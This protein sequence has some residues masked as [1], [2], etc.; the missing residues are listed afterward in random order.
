MEKIKVLLEKYIN[1]VKEMDETINSVGKK[2]ILLDLVMDASKNQLWD[3]WYQF[4]QIGYYT[5]DKRKIR[6]FVMDV[7][8]N[9]YKEDSDKAFDITNNHEIE[10]AVFNALHKDKEEYLNENDRIISKDEIIESIYPCLPD[11]VAF[12]SN[13]Y[14]N[15]WH[16]TFTYLSEFLCKGTI[17]SRSLKIGSKSFRMSGAYDLDLTG[18]EIELDQNS[19]RDYLTNILPSTT[20]N[21]DDYFKTDQYK[22]DVKDYETSRPHVFYDTSYDYDESNEA[23]DEIRKMYNES[24]DILEVSQSEIDILN[25][26]YKD[27]LVYPI[28]S[29][30]NRQYADDKK[31]KYIYTYV[32]TLKNKNPNSSLNVKINSSNLDKLDQRIENYLTT[33][34]DENVSI[35][36]KYTDR[37]K[38]D[39]YKSADGQWVIE[40]K[41]GWIT[42]YG[43]NYIISKSKVNAIYEL[44]LVS[45]VSD[46]D[47][48]EAWEDYD[49]HAFANDVTVE[50]LNNNPCSF[51]TYGSAGRVENKFDNLKEVFK[52][53]KECGGFNQLKDIKWSIESEYKGGEFYLYRDRFA[54]GGWQWQDVNGSFVHRANKD[55]DYRKTRKVDES[56]QLN[57]VNLV[58]I[59]NDSKATDPK[60]VKLSQSLYTEY[61][62]VDS[63][64]TLLFETDSQTRSNLG[65]QQKIFYE[66][67][68]NLLD[69]VDQNEEIS[70]EDVVDILTGDV[71]ISCTCFTP[72]MQV[73][74]FKGKKSI[75]DIEPED[76][77]LTHDGTY[78]KVLNIYENDISE[79]ILMIN[80]VEMTKSHRVAVYRDDSV[81]FINA[82]EIRIGDKLIKPKAKECVGYVYDTINN[83]NDK[84]YIGSHKST[85]YDPNYHGSGLI[86]NNAINKY[87]LENFINKPLEVIYESEEQ[88]RNRETDYIQRYLNSDMICYNISPTSF[89][90]DTFS[91]LDDKAKQAKR[92]KISASVKGRVYVN[93]DGVEKRVKQDDISTYVGLGY[94]IG[95]LP[96]YV[97]VFKT[98]QKP[99][100]EE[101]KKKIS[102]IKKE[103]WR[104]RK[105]NDNA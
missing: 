57:E 43:T 37:V 56:E 55:D 34:L 99:R 32:A 59:I 44:K 80:G 25:K 105:E 102:E 38:G 10:N 70:E 13:Y 8:N 73:T 79:D 49:T 31:S 64:G 66:G 26:K 36:K 54:K 17:E 81:I 60:R 84:H 35:P 21:E 40:L 51:V 46:Q 15:Y 62:G 3:L 41:D 77:V 95:R 4:T 9:C 96:E 65:H 72:E 100:S 93:K 23:K 12:K 87:G 11:G 78:K 83:I 101:S 16:I 75:K 91:R 103:Y 7:I 22:K 1:Y 61:K 67:F 58:D 5:E 63:D 97:E 86:L 45:K 39:I 27:N 20:D 2:Q 42:D 28:E 76:L 69:K 30:R 94:K 24:E 92:E 68:F 88:L 50:E 104:K 82:D 47:L 71:N 90:G 53:V 33:N 52:Y 19:L 74:T 14:N 98:L 89:D 18:G 48:D 29:F 6:Q 85:S